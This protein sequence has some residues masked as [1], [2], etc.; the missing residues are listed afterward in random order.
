MSRMDSRGRSPSTLVTRNILV[1]GRRTSIRLEPALWDALE[2]ISRREGLSL[3]EICD[4]IDRRRRESS[5]TAAIRVFILSYYRA[6]ATE[7]GHADAGHGSLDAAG[8]A[9]RGES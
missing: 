8:M 5:L 1:G 9:R 4:R 7:A 6:A 2:E 3:H